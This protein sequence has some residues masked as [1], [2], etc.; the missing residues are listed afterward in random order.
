MALISSSPR[1]LA[2]NPVR[3]QNPVEDRHRREGMEMGPFV[4][5]DVQEKRG[6]PYV[7][8]DS[9]YS[10]LESGWLSVDGAAGEL[11]AVL[12][13][14]HGKPVVGIDAPRMPISRPRTWRCSR[15]TWRR[16]D[17]GLAGRHCEIAVRALGLANP[18]WTPMAPAAPKWM[19]L[20]FELFAMSTLRGYQT[21][22]VF[23]SATY[24]ALRRDG[25]THHVPVPLENLVLGAKDMLDAVG[26]A[27]TVARFS[28]GLGSEVGGGDG[29]GTIVLPTPVEDHPALR[30]PELP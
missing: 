14:L 4:G 28:R 2:G 10:V 3:H 21:L 1:S 7:V 30:W 13:G 22:E 16:S 25:S 19:Q 29:L 8:M 18:Q 23:P 24:E 20:G 9:D 26:A 17:A 15:G 6:I 11:V 27:Y 12:D 5:V